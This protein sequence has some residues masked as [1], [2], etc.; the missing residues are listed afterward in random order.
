MFVELT[1][2]HRYL[3]LQ[4]GPDATT[5]C[6]PDIVWSTR[7]W[8]I[9]WNKLISIIDQGDT[10]SETAERKK[11]EKNERKEKKRKEKKEE[12]KDKK[13]KTIKKKKRKRMRVRTAK[14]YC[15]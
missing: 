1:D 13:Q 14:L 2:R 11:K 10:L 12:K 8:S 7:L 4:L 6:C 5:Q 15:V 9:W 3:S